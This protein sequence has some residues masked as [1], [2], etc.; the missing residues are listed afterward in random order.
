MFHSSL[1]VTNLEN[2]SDRLLE[3]INSFM[4]VTENVSG[5][6]PYQS[7]FSQRLIFETRKNNFCSVK[8]LQRCHCVHSFLFYSL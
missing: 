4:K 3:R 2:G 7:Q 6:V 8:P 5:Y 1:S